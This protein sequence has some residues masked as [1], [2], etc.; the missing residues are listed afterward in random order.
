MPYLDLAKEKK[1]TSVTPTTNL[2]TKVEAAL[3]EGDL[4][5]MSSDEKLQHY[6][7][8]CESL[9]LNPHTKPFGYIT[10]N[11][12]LTLYALRAATDQ[13]RSLHGVSVVET[14]N[15]VQN[16]IV[17]VTCVVRDKCGREDS[18]IGCV[19][20]SG[21]SGDALANAFMKAI[22]KAKRRATLSLCGLGWLDE[23]EVETLRDAVISAPERHHEHKK[24]AEKPKEQNLIDSKPSSVVPVV[25]EM[26]PVNGS[27]ATKQQLK[28]ISK[29]LKDLNFEEVD[30]ADWKLKMREEYGVNSAAELSKEDADTV[31]SEL[32]ALNI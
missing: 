1:E 3:I 21:L 32:Q 26:E 28:T 15:V 23:T 9:G 18:D 4:S 30:L 27:N 7:N 25:N 12:K 5:K 29:L 22:T 8:V 13:L 31:I 24:D 17:T 14:K 6:R 10:L 2:S 16:G 19:N 11:G 20:I